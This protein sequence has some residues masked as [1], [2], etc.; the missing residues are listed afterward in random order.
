MVLNRGHDLFD[1]S[2]THVRKCELP[3]EGD[4]DV[5]LLVGVKSSHSFSCSI[6]VFLRYPLGFLH[7]R[8]TERLTLVP[9]SV[10]TVETVLVE[11]VLVGVT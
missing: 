7:S 11:P 9:N 5:P 3:P 8:Y 4:H 10:N 2:S 6:S 1:R